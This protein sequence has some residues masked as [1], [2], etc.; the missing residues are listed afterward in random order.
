MTIKTQNTPR[1]TATHSTKGA[2]PALNAKSDPKVLNTA[3]NNYISGLYAAAAKSGQPSQIFKS[4]PDKKN[5]NTTP[6]PIGPFDTAGEKVT[7]PQFGGTM[8]GK[9]FSVHFDGGQAFFTKDG[10]N[11]WFNTE[12][13]NG[14]GKATS[15]LWYGPIP[16]KS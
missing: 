9:P 4:A 10:R 6:I 2:G 14:W 13:G 1:T 5:M 3:I 11:M 16:T 12:G 15:G 7:G 8:Q